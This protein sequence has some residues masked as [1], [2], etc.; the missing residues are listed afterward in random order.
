MK[1]FSRGVVVVAKGYPPDL[2]GVQTYSR[3]L[4]RELRRR[5]FQCVVVTSRPGYRG[6]VREEGIGVINVGVASQFNVAWRMFWILRRLVGSKRR[7]RWQAGW[8]T[9]WRVGTL[10]TL[11]RLPF[12]LTVHGREIRDDRYGV[13][14]W[15][16]R[17]VLAS[18]REIVAIS[19]YSFDNFVDP[20]YRNKASWAWNGASDWASE[21]GKERKHT[22]AGPA[23]P[24]YILFAARMVASKNVLGAIHGFVGFLHGGGTGELW[25]AGDGEDRVAA[26][27]AVR[28]LACAQHVRFLGHLSGPKL[29][30]AYR[31]ADIFLH[32]HVGIETFCL[33][34]ADAMVAG[35]PVVSGSDGAPKEYLVSGRGVLVNGH[36]EKG[37]A[38]AL[39]NLQMA[40][41]KRFLMSELAAQFASVNFTWR[42]HAA[43]ACALLADDGWFK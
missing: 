14:G 26:E 4:A 10:L 8:A 24:V 32:P 34:I 21:L 2:G 15:L 37:I 19:Q 33:A 16:M 18:A 11:L 41:E 6:V 20:R 13:R 22:E 7:A 36:D 17:R 40:P 35:L 31:K 23:R 3:E 29:I 28:D 5:R 1:S 9:T 12:L 30:D 42:K 25:L 27:A 38:L 39:L 43:R